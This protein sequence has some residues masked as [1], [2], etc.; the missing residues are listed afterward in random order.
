MRNRLA[1]LSVWVI[2]SGLMT[3]MAVAQPKESETHQFTV[4]Q[5]VEY[6]LKNSIQ[7]KNAL[8]DIK[9]AEQVNREYT[10]LAYPQLNASGGINY[11]PK[12]PVQSF[13]NFISMATY[14]VLTQEGVKNGSGTPI[15][16]PSD[17]G[18]INAQFGTKYTASAGLDLS[19]ILFDG[20]V[21][22]GLQARSTN[23]KLAQKNAEITQEAINANIQKIYF[24]LVI[25]KMQMSKVDANITLL[26][27]LLHD[28]KEIYKNGFAEK[29]D[30]DKTTVSLT[31]LQTEKVKLQNS[32]DAGNASLKFLM[33]MPQVD[34]LVLTDTLTEQNIKEDL[35]DDSYNYKDRKEVQALELANR[36]NLYNVKRYKLSYVPSLVAFGQYSKNAQRNS[37]NIF[38]FSLPWFTTAVVGVKLNVPLFD[39]M[40]KDAK[41]KQ[42]RLEYQKTTNL[43]NNMK[44]SVDMEVQQTRWKLKSAILTIDA[45]KKNMELAEDV[46]NQTKKKYEQGLGS[47]LEITNAWKDLQVAQSDYYAALYDA[48]IAKVDY[49]KAIGKLQ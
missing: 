36:L 21:F 34:V 28:T 20:Q 40:M 13:P 12:V 29:L 43:L 9:K 23:L 14:E 3:N 16:K 1:K 45:Q 41:I 5:S 24:Q 19:Q 35:L 17:Y 25:A 32:I 48:I 46:Y 10:A 15:Q 4:Q 26:E 22:V 42:A 7:V 31:N 8:L 27:K 39:G 38:D 37:F 44:E 47:N 2:A 33:G 49:H 18:F 11:F 6:A 30:V